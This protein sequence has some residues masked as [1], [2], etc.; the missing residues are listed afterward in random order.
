MLRSEEEIGRSSSLH[1]SRHSSMENLRDTTLPAGTMTT[2]TTS[3]SELSTKGGPPPMAVLDD[4]PG[5]GGDF[6]RRRNSGGTGSNGNVIE[7]M[8]QVEAN[9]SFD[10]GEGSG[11]VAPFDMT[12]FQMDVQNLDDV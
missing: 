7:G 8:D 2:F 4:V 1:G 3:L 5:E 12:G 9:A 6:L 10:S 11:A